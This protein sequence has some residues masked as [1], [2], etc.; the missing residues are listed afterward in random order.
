MLM[1]MMLLLLT[2]GGRD[3]YLYVSPGGDWG[4]DSHLLLLVSPS[5]SLTN[6]LVISIDK[7]ASPRGRSIYSH[8]LKST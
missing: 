6:R 7:Q 3:V 2:V 8:L 4:Y 1:L 5:S